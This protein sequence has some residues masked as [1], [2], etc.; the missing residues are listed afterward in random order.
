MKI[1]TFEFSGNE[2]TRKKKLG[3]VDDDR[4]TWREWN[5]V[6]F[7]S[8]HIFTPLR[9]YKVKMTKRVTGSILVGIFLGSSIT[10]NMASGFSLWLLRR[11]KHRSQFSKTLNKFH[12]SVWKWPANKW[13]PV[14][15]TISRFIHAFTE[16]E[17]ILNATSQ[18]KKMSFFRKKNELDQLKMMKIKEISSTESERRVFLFL[19]GESS[20]RLALLFCC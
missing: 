15:V 17:F 13:P 18:R 16:I 8:H 2:E 7:F 3:D 14:V 6:F 5:T 4:E 9:L 11:N 19:R 12:F 20:V 1:T 10:T